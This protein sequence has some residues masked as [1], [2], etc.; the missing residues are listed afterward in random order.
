MCNLKIF[1]GNGPNKYINYH[2]IDFELDDASIKLTVK[3]EYLNEIWD[4][5]ISF[6]LAQYNGKVLQLNL[7]SDSTPMNLQAVTLLD[8]VDRSSKVSTLSNNLENERSI[9]GFCRLVFDEDIFISFFDNVGENIEVIGTA[10]EFLSVPQGKTLT[11][12][13]L[14]QSSLF[15]KQYKTFMYKAKMIGAIDHYNSIAYLECQ[16]DALTRVVKAILPQITV[17]MPTDCLDVLNKADSY[18]VLDI[19]GQDKIMAEF[20]NK[21][22]VRNLQQEYYNEKS[23]N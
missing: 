20:A 21:Q 14:E 15:A 19:K 4:R 16:V 9:F 1:N 5:T 7:Y 22:R 17:D 8:Y 10:M 3:V 6:N 12:A 23:T 18:S 2:K 13:L 11:G